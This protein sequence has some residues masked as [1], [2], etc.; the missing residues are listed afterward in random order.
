MILQCFRF[1]VVSD[2]INTSQELNKDL[3][4]VGSWANKWKMSFNPDPLK[5]AQ[6]V[7]FFTENNQLYHPPLLF[8]NSTVQQ[9]STQNHLG[10]HLN[11]EL[12][13][14]HHI[15]EKTDQVNKGIGLFVN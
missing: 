11:E 8:N 3:D 13:F 14:K 12:I 15:N 4:K 6:A 7:I 2:P 10:I 1:S 9:T 5:Q